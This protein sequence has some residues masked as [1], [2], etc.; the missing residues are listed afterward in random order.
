MEVIEA[1]KQKILSFAIQGKLVPQN[2]SDEPA[3]VLLEKIKAEKN[4]LVQEGKI[5]KDKQE[6]FIEKTA[7][8][9][10]VEHIGKE[11]K[12]ITDEIPF[13]IPENWECCR[14]ASIIQTVSA[15]QYQIPQ[16]LINSKGKYPVVSQSQNLIEGYSDDIEK[17]LKHNIPCFVFGD[18][19]RCLKLIDFDFIVGADGTKLFFTYQNINNYLFKC[20]QYLIIN[21]RNRGY[22]RHFQ[23]LI[24]LLIPLPPLAEQERIVAK[25]E[26]LNKHIEKL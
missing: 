16:S 1:L 23:F 3:S 11:I 18:H 14:L 4:K 2:P 13:E 25:I 8:G 12:D 21:M 15:K 20:L 7:D 22:S 24:Q 26:E 5:K 19:T 17:V 10:Y 9:K 6:S